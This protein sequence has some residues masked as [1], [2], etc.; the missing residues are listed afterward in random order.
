[1]TSIYSISFPAIVISYPYL[2]PSIPVVAMDVEITVF[3]MGT[4]WRMTQWQL[5]PRHIA[6]HY[7]IQIT[8]LLLLAF[9]NNGL[10]GCKVSLMFLAQRNCHCGVGISGI[11]GV[12]CCC[13]QWEPL[14]VDGDN[15]FIQQFHS[16]GRFD[17]GTLVQRKGLLMNR[18][19]ISLCPSTWAVR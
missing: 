1:M 17:L 10:H 19:C 7:S 9:R 11:V 13:R 15:I 4:R 6:P 8:N 5:M 16:S 3:C 2:N 14:A 12:W 18:N